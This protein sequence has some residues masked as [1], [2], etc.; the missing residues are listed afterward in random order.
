METFVIIFSFVYALNF[1]L[2]TI[3]LLFSKKKSLPNN[4]LPDV[5]VIVAAKNEE[6]NI[7]QCI[8]SLLKIDYPNGKIEIILV[9]DNSNDRTAEIMKGFVSSDNRLKY[10]VPEIS[11]GKLKG[12]VNALNQAIKISQGEIIFTTD[13]DI[14]V[15]PSWVKEM[16]KYY[17]DSTG[18]VSSYSVIKPKGFFESIQSV[19]WLFLLSIACGSHFY[20]APVSCLGNNMSFR[21]KAYDEVGGFEKIDFSVTEDF[22]LL[23]SVVRK[24]KWKAKYPL[25]KKI[26]NQ[27]F[28]CETVKELLNQK[29]RWAVGGLGIFTWGT[30]SGVLILCSSILL[31]TLWL[32]VPTDIFL[33]FLLS[34]VI[35]DFVFL[36]PTVVTYKLF[37]GLLYF[38]LFEIYVPIYF[39]ITTLRVIFNKQILWKE[40]KI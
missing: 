12:K 26:V 9:N 16:I 36:L 30:V 8:E 18:I 15:K 34:K 38:I 3:G 27:T 19:D 2:L 28:A 14:I 39:I 40:E 37:K 31:M 17:D 29:K 22:I 32:I 20:N 1:L 10:F 11:T 23:Q 7:S 5:S 21:R 25:D 6:K 33:L 13:A 4:F 35:F 24:T